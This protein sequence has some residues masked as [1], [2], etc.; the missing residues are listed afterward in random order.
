MIKKSSVAAER[1]KVN[2][3][4]VMQPSPSPL[5]EVKK[6]PIVQ[7]VSL[8]QTSGSL[9]KIHT[10][11]SLYPPF[12]YTDAVIKSCS[13][14]EPEICTLNSYKYGKPRIYVKNTFPS[15]EKSQVHL[16]H[17]T[18]LELGTKNRPDH[19]NEHINMLLSIN[20]NFS[21]KSKTL[22]NKA[23]CHVNSLSLLSGSNKMINVSIE[24]TVMCQSLI[25]TGST[26]C[27]ISVENF[28][29]LKINEFQP[30]SMIM[31]VAGSSLKDNIIGCIDLTIKIATDGPSPFSNKMTFLIAHHINGYDMILGANFLLNPLHVMAITPYTIILFEK[32]YT[33]CAPF[34]SKESKNK[35]VLLKNCEAFSLSV[36]KS[37]DIALKCSLDMIF[38]SFEK[39]TPL[40]TFLSKGLLVEKIYKESKTSTCILTVKNVGTSHVEVARDF[41]VGTLEISNNFEKNSNILT[42]PEL[43]SMYII[44]DPSST[45]KNETLPELDSKKFNK[46]KTVFAKTKTLKVSEVQ[47]NSNHA[48]L[49]PDT[50]KA[51]SI[52]AWEKPNSLY[53]L[54]SRIYSLEN[55]QKFIPQLSELMF[56]LNHILKSGIFS[57]DKKVNEAWERIKSII[58]LDI[59]LT[60]P[61]KDEQLVMTCDASKIA[62]SCILW[63]EKNYK[64]KVVECFSKLFSHNDSLKSTHFKETYAIV[65]GF[66]QFRPFFFLHK[67][68][69]R[70]Y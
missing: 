24:D 8:P 14:K 18:S 11:T 60:I 4:P 57:W 29:K 59:K 30:I 63:V 12:S 51:K 6:A 3:A 9:K 33:V 37:A 53:T 46:Y 17:D 43:S 26:H 16:L 40:V 7:L 38:G 55:W 28:K 48:I 54:Q 10:V 42:V 65:E 23:T 20:K 70:F 58:S 13:S 45:Q 22:R 41:P 47:V 35:T 25:D 15:T 31:M 5:Q 66:R 44:L 27:L 68:C 64:L 32:D 56:P 1:E 19:Y 39:F 67:T 34:V 61:Q 69:S 2:K 52:L 50:A 62:I 36:N 21:P 49:A